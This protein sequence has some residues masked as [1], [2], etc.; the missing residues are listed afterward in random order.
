MPVGFFRR[1]DAL[2]IGNR[3]NRETVTQ[4][5]NSRLG[6]ALFV[7]YSA[8]Y[9]AFTLLNALAP[10]MAR[11]R[12]IGN[13]NLAVSSGLGLIVLALVMALAYGVLCRPESRDANSTA[14]GEPRR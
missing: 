7:I 4:K 9:L 10:Q 1:R 8:V 12:P 6:L 14:R 11:L 2:E 3:M 13:L 5:H